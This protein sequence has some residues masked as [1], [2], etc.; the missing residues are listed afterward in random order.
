MNISCSDWTYFFMLAAA[1]DT[2]ILHQ[3]AQRILHW[4]YPF[5]DSYL[6]PFCSIP[7]L[8]SGFVLERRWL[9]KMKDFR[10]TIFETTVFTI[11]FSLLFEFVFPYLFPEF[12]FDPYDFLAYAA[13]AIVF[14][15]VNRLV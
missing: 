13:G 6:D 1:G 15:S 5:I 11:A 10:L 2:I 7:F 8:L 3:I 9:L 14:Y 12:I 4:S